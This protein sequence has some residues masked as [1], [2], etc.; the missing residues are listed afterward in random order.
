[1][2]YRQPY[3]ITDENAGYVDGNPA[4]GIEGSAVP[5]EAVEHPQREIVN[6]I[7][8]AGLIPDR[9]DL[10]QL[11]QALGL[12]I[13]QPEKFWL[14]KRLTA[15]LTINVNAAT[16]NNATADGSLQF[17]FKTIQAACNYVAQNLFLGPYNVTIQVAAGTY[18]ES[19]S[20]PQYVRTT[21][22]IVLSGAG[23]A[24]IVNPA[25]VGTWGVALSS[26]VSYVI[27]NMQIN[28]GYTSTVAGYCSCI[29]AAGGTIT[30]DGCTLLVPPGYGGANSA[31]LV[32]GGGFVALGGTGNTITIT[33][34][35][36][37]WG[38]L[39]NGGN[40][41]LEAN[42]AITG[43][44]I[45]ATISVN[46]LGSFVRQS[47]LPIIT[48]SVTGTRYSATLLGIITVQGGGANFIPGT[49]AGGVSTGAQYA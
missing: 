46:Y 8:R 4:L 33:A 43:A 28:V 48:G 14:L 3:G 42:L 18:A 23:A 12:L 16:G 26:A 45:S 27:K 20:L 47:A 13:P 9:N 39:V 31:P 5:F 15:S 22:T 38:I 10:T 6:V 37:G 21:G 24:T 34:T 36:A 7:E 41:S 35:S 11:Y 25:N 1:M 44:V 17:P 2:K 30:L 29:Y 19:V 32:V 49:L 40:V